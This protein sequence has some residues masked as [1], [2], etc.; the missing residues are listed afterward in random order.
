METTFG[1]DHIQAMVLSG[2][3]CRGLSD[4]AAEVMAADGPLSGR[5]LCGLYVGER[6]AVWVSGSDGLKNKPFLEFA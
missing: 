2:K 5:V 3:I 6:E 1:I 4:F